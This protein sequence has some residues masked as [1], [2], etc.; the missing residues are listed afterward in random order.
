[1]KKHF[2]RAFLV[3]FMVLGL[4]STGYCHLNPWGQ[5]DTNRL[6]GKVVPGYL[7]STGT[8]IAAA[9]S[10]TTAQLAIPV[11]YC[12]VRKAVANDDAYLAGTLANGTKGQ[13]L[14]IFITVNSGSKNFVI[15]PTTKTG[16]TTL[17]FDAEKDQAT[18]LYIDDT[19][20]WVLLSSTSVTVGI[21]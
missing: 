1:M 14:T 8:A 6:L 17:T 3:A 13:L 12:Y 9:T 16:F 18:L 4:A 7:Q 5:T 15:T 21:P 11:S 2:L 10:L 20:G 19:T